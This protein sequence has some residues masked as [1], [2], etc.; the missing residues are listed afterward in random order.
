[1]GDAMSEV[2]G[3]EFRLV[4]RPERLPRSYTLRARKR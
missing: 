2:G 3:G 4:D 1:M